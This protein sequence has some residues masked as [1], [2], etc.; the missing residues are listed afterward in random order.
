[1]YSWIRCKTSITRNTR[2]II[3]TIARKH[4]LLASV[5]E[6]RCG[7]LYEEEPCQFQVPGFYF[8]SSKCATL[9]VWL[10]VGN[11]GTSAHDLQLCLLAEVLNICMHICTSSLCNRTR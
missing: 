5:V 6:T 1:M 10:A 9:D 11:D 8:Y 3:L 2:K 7:Y 4:L